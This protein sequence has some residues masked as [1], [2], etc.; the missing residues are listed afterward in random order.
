MIQ[1]MRSSSDFFAAHPIFSRDEFV[2]REALGSRHP[3]TVDALLAYHLGCG[4]IRRV[5]RGLYAATGA[6]AG[7]AYDGLVVGSRVAPDAVLAYGSAL[8]AHGLLASVTRRV[9]VLT[10]RSIRPWIFG[11]RRFTAVRPPVGA[12]GAALTFGIATVRMGSLA[13][14]V[15][16]IERTVVDVLRRPLLVGG[17]DE[18]RRSLNL[19]RALDGDTIVSY[20]RLLA[21]R[22]SQLR[23]VAA[24]LDGRAGEFP[25]DAE[26]ASRVELLRRTASSADCVELRPTDNCDEPEGGTPK[27]RV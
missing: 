7:L 23:A 14:R 9:T 2:A 8:E 27:G 1:R 25:A 16:S 6:A 15:T 26:T 17:K 24:F 3:K 10:C 21:P 13:V 19:V 18:V 5:R 11:G 4:R 12:D 20:L 22:D